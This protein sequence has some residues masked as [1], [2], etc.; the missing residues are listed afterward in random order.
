[1]PGRG[2]TPAGKGKPF[3][4]GPEE[5][6]EKGHSSCPTM[7]K[8]HF[9]RDSHPR[10]PDAPYRCPQP[11]PTSRTISSS[12]E[13]RESPCTPSYLNIP[14]LGSPSPLH[15]PRRTCCSA[16][17]Q[18][19][20]ASTWVIARS[21]NEPPAPASAPCPGYCPPA[22]QRSGKSEMSSATQEKAFVAF[23]LLV[24]AEGCGSEDG[25]QGLPLTG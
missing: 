3:Q 21:P 24:P 7:S 6:P 25:L 2:T 20:L 17:A 11:S 16:L 13:T 1:M 19:I 18:V 15:Q 5:E 14:T 9:R 22:T 4:P 10:L 12:P 23:S 8:G